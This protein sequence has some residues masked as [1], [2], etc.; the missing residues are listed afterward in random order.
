V[1]ADR[2]TVP[3]MPACVLI[4]LRL[5]EMLV[6]RS[7]F[8]REREQRSRQAL[9]NM[10]AIAGNPGALHSFRAVGT[11]LGHGMADLA[12]ILDPWVSSLAV[13]CCRRPG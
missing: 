5:A 4:G 12:A 9:V 11:W 7:R 13:W 1:L 2:V 3:T 8:M 10:G 6:G